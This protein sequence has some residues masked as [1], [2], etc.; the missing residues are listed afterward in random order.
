MYDHVRKLSGFFHMNGY[1]VRAGELVIWPARTSTQKLYLKFLE[2][3]AIVREYQ[4]LVRL[5][6][7]QSRSYVDAHCFW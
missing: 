4:I 2:L 7:D 6:L 1:T 5:D 3:M